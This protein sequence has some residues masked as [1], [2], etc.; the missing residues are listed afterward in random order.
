MLTTRHDEIAAVILEPVVQGAGGMWFGRCPR[1][2][3]VLLAGVWIRP[4]ND[5][6]YLMPPYVIVAEDLRRLRTLSAGG[7]TLW[8]RF[9]RFS[10]SFFGRRPRPKPTVA[11]AMT[12]YALRQTERARSPNRHH[13]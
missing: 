2:P 1:R 4:F 5:L 11:P 6:I 8:R 7:W 13:A 9:S 10:G 3:R 12:Q